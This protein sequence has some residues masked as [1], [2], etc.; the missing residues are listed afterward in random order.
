[1]KPSVPVFGDHA[2]ARWRER[3]AAFDIHKEYDASIPYGCQIG[4]GIL[5]L[6]P[7]DAVFAIKEGNFVVTVLTKE[8][9]VVNVQAFIRTNQVLKT[10]TPDQRLIEM[11]YAHARS[12]FDGHDFKKQCLQELRAK[13]FDTSNARLMQNYRKAFDE[14]RNETKAKKLP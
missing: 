4:T 1:M 5:L 13:G 9:A 8:Q 10:T 6:S 3:F 11:A 7:C 12:P 14:M 2:L